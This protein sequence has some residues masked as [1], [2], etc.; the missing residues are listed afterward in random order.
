[1]RSEPTDIKRL[2]RTR[3]C[4]PGKLEIDGN[5]IETRNSERI[6]VNNKQKN[7][8][9]V[10]NLPPPRNCRHPTVQQIAPKASQAIGKKIWLKLSGFWG[11]TTEMQLKYGLI[12]TKT[13]NPTEA[14]VLVVVASPFLRRIEYLSVFRQA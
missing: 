6:A 14:I 12:K 4:A 11:S 13:L 7:M 8:I 1:M 5:A 10:V 2:P 3:S 9:N